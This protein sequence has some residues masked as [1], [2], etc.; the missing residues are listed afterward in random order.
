L[1]EYML[2]LGYYIFRP[3]AHQGPADLICVNEEGEIVLL[4][5]K[6]DSFRT[7]PGRKKPARIY[8]KRSDLQ[9]K[10]NVRMAYVDEETRAVVISPPLVV[11]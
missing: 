9:K 2:R 6:S 11:D 10:L 8:R 7:N 5:S 4:D 1:T 3:L